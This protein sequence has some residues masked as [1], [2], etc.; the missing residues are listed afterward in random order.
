MV[1]CVG[2][3]WGGK[4]TFV[5]QCFCICVCLRWFYEFYE[6][7]LLGILLNDVSSTMGSDL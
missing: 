3:V 6:L 1:V 2:E 4:Q 7:A 5:C